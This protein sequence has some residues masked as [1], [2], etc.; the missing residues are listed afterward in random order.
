M[1]S[2][3]TADLDIKNLHYSVARKYY[4]KHT[5]YVDTG[6]IPKNE[7]IKIIDNAV[8]QTVKNLKRQNIIINP[9]HRFNLVTNKENQSLGYG[10]LW[11]LTND[12]IIYVMDSI[13]MDQRGSN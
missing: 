6:A 11:L 13:Q 3:P 8:N 1:S 4:D 7:L 5:L 9:E 12:C 2:T 10:Y